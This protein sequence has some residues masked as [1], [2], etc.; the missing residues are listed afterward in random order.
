M[1]IVHCSCI[2]L[3]GSDIAT[4]LGFDIKATIAPKGRPNRWHLN[5]D[6]A[7]A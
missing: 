6:L 1:G 4:F 3:M 7:E 2:R 5:S